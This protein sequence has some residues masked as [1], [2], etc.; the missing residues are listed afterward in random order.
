MRTYGTTAADGTAT[1]AGSL[2]PATSPSV[3]ANHTNV[4]RARSSV[5]WGDM[6]IANR[7]V[8]I[9]ASAVDASTPTLSHH[10]N[11]ATRRASTR[12]ADNGPKSARSVR[13]DRLTI[14]PT[15]APQPAAAGTTTSNAISR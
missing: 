13:P 8:S 9:H 7:A 11:S 12:S 10:V 4:S 6:T 15:Q 3:P 5:A 2:R 1:S 14:E